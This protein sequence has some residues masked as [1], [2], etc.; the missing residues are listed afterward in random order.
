MKA[1]KM[2]AGRQTLF[3][4]DQRFKMPGMDNSVY[5]SEHLFSIKLNGDRLQE[6]VANWDQVLSGLDKAPDEQTLRSLV[7]L[8]LR[9]CEAMEQDLA[10]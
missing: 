7:L 4:I 5:E 2:Q 6:F 1:G 8:S 9:H 10:Y 3:I